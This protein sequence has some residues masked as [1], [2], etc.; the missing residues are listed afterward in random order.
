MA[1]LGDSAIRLYPVWSWSQVL[2]GNETGKA[3]NKGFL[4]MFARRIQGFRLVGN[5]VKLQN[6]LESSKYDSQANKWSHRRDS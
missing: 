4:A 5:D 3:R 2:F 1:E 6:S